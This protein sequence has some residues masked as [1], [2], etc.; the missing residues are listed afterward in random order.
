MLS[1]F[2]SNALK[3]SYK[4]EIFIS[5]EIR[6]TT[7]LPPTNKM[8]SPQ[9]TP[10]NNLAPKD[11]DDTKDKKKVIYFVIRD[12]GIGMDEEQLMI[13][14]N[15]LKNELSSK[16]T[17]NSAGIGLG[18]RVASNLLKFLGPSD[19]NNLFLKSKKD[20]GTEISFFLQNM[21]NIP[22]TNNYNIKEST[23]NTFS[24]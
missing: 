16:H 21:N 18:L 20:E 6:E 4:G 1:I 14:I 24:A 22:N 2:I 15:S 19:K 12:Q 23:T 11:K 5:Y 10:K 13:A 7:A 8:I 17:S 3:F 9:Q